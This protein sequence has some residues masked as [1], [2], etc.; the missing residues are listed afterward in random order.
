VDPKI[1]NQ[2]GFVHRNKRFVLH[3]AERLK[4]M[5]FTLY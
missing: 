2:N 5:K 1:Y 4:F 3:I